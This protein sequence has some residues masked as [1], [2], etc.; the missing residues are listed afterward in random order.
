MIYLCT[1]EHMSD[2][3]KFFKALNQWLQRRENDICEAKHSDA[4][5]KQIRNDICEGEDLNS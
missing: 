4:S 2:Q 3:G 5:I 1:A